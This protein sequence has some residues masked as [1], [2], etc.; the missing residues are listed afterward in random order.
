MDIAC[1]NIP[2]IQLNCLNEIIL[3]SF[4]PLNKGTLYTRVWFMYRLSM[5]FLPSIVFSFNDFKKIKLLKERSGIY[6]IYCKTEDKFYIGSAADLSKRLKSHFN[7][8]KRSNKNLQE[9]ILKYGK[10]DFYILVL[11]FLGPTNFITTTN[12]VVAE[13][14]FLQS[15]NITIDMLYNVVM[16]AQSTYGFKHSDDTKQKLRLLRLGKKLSDA[17]KQK[18]SDLLSGKLNPFFG[19]NHTPEFKERMSL[20]HSGENNPMFGKP[21]SAAFTY[22]MY[23]DKT[24]LNNHQSKSL[25]FVNIITGVVMH[26]DT[27]TQAALHFK[28]SR[29]T[30]TDCIKAKRLYKKEWEITLI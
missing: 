22:H 27:I 25:I 16:N 3:L 8:P 12:L 13:N 23:K 30:F 4:F 2:D 1:L 6:A 14:L 21:K 28:T 5:T 26:F 20:L 19:K 18:I 29:C 7:N 10:E 24:G 17:T 11:L 9:A 15:P